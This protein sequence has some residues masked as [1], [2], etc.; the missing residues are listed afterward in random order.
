MSRVSIAP[1]M[2]GQLAT[3]IA[4]TA[5]LSILTASCG[6]SGKD[7][8]VGLAETTVTAPRAQ[9]TPLPPAEVAEVNRI[10]RRVQVY[11]FGVRRAVGH[12]GQAPGPA[13]LDA[14]LDGIDRM[15]QLARKS[16]YGVL[17]NGV[18]LRL[19]L[20]DI[21]EDLEGENCSP[22]IQERIDQDLASIPEQ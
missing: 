7:Q 10:E 14:A 4:I 11:C 3:V 18:G 21:A 1:G 16:P 13:E 17:P 22:E 12:V 6:G 9:Y 8:A 15:A 2:Q 19:T 5:V 20:G